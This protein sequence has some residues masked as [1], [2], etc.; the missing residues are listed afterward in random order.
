MKDVFKYFEGGK[1]GIK[2]RFAKMT[3]EAVQDYSNED[4]CALE[5]DANLS[6]GTFARI[7]TG[8]FADINAHFIDET[9]DCLM[10]DLI[11]GL[12]EWNF[13]EEDRQ[14]WIDYIKENQV[15]SIS[16]YVDDAYGLV[17]FIVCL[18]AL[19]TL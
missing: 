11:Q 17:K 4:I 15:V 13:P 1:E 12:G 10:F 5:Q 19:R 6:P 14:F 18:E 8:D 16:S 7:K 9:Q 2:S 3:I